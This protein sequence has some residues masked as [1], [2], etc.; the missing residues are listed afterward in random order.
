MVQLGTRVDRAM[1]ERLNQQART[2]GGYYSSYRREGAIPGFIFKTRE[3]AE[4]F[5]EAVRIALGDGGCPQEPPTIQ[6]P[7]PPATAPTAAINLC[8]APDWR[9]RFFHK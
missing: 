7:Q 2:L 4:K 6:P 5:V 9:N 3:P 1:Y 8:G